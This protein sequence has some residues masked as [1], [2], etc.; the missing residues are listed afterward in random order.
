LPIGTGNLWAVGN[1]PVS[2]ALKHGRKLVVH[3]GSIPTVASSGGR[4]LTRLA[5]D[6]DACKHL[7]PPRLMPVVRP[8]NGRCVDLGRVWGS[9]KP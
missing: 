6:G 1:K 9:L 4:C 3:W 7:M 8:R 5:A 2:V